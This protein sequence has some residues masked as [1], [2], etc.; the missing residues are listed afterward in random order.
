MA[1]ESNHIYVAAPCTIY[2]KFPSGVFPR[3]V[4]FK[5]ISDEVEYFRQLFGKLNRIK[6][7]LIKEGDYYCNQ[8]FDLVKK[9][10]IEIP[11]DFPRLPMSERNRWKP[12]T[13]VDNPELTG[14]PARIYTQTGIIEHGP[15][16]YRLPKCVRVF[17]DLHEQ[18]HL[19]YKT[20]EYCDLWALI[21]YL[22]MG[23]N[24]STAYWTLC[25]ILKK[26]PANVQ[27][28]EQLV[29]NIKKTQK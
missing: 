5:S 12:V 9:V 20:E 2:I 19:F 14:T 11:K 10:P 22:R 1:A 25:N 23:Y 8:P 16:Y 3:Y 15:E 6:L 27:R 28:I 21:N 18:G 26:T 13:Y 29:F 7:N 24:R 4:E 17:I